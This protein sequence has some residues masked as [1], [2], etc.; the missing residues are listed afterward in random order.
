MTQ[1]E[2]DQ[3][4]ANRKIEAREEAGEIRFWQ[5]LEWWAGLGLGVALTGAVWSWCICH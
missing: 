3:I 1:C 2:M 4:E 5:T